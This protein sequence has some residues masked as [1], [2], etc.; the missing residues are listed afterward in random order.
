V[1]QIYFGLS[2][3]AY[4]FM[5]T[6]TPAYGLGG[7]T[8]AALIVGAMTFVGILFVIAFAFVIAMYGF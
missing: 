2:A 1:L 4:P 3:V 7:W 5:G 8:A 6:P